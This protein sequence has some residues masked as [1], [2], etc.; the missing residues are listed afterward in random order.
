[1][2]MYNDTTK[3]GNVIK[4]VF[5]LT[6]FSHEI[7]TL[8]S[9]DKSQL[10]TIIKAQQVTN[11]K[12]SYKISTLSILLAIS[13]VA[14]I[15]L[16]FIFK[17]N[18]KASNQEIMEQKEKEITKT[19][20]TNDTTGNE[21]VD[22]SNN[23]TFQSD[24]VI[25]SASSNT[26][27]DGERKTSNRIR[28]FTELKTA[29]MHIYGMSIQGKGHIND[30][31]PCQDC[32][33]VEI[34]DTEKNIGIAVVSDGAGS[35]L[36]SAEGSKIVCE[37]SIKYLKMA[38]NKFQWLESKNLPNEMVWDKVIR[39]VIRLVQFDLNEK[40]KLMEC[41][42]RSLAATFILLYFTPEKTYFAHVG[43]GRAGVKTDEG[44]K[45]ILTPHKGEEANQTVFVSNE[46]LNPSDLKIS[47]A[48]VPE[49]I[50]IDKP[51]CAFILMSDGCEDGLWMKNKKENLP[52]GDF[53]YTA[54]NQPFVPAIEKLIQV[55]NDKQYETK[56]E[57]VLFQFM[58]RY[59]DNLKFEIDDKTLCIGVLSH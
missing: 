44:W 41:E 39:E 15:F 49:T 53:K 52:D 46:I 5:P 30:N 13:I 59:N 56:K 17:K 42:L 8:T 25:S 36:N 16:F 11:S 4:E 40:A 57:Q 21:K 45:A 1:M 3:V 51:I 20:E 34:L 14:N 7:D 19:A 9:K 10:I 18:K 33:Q 28:L 29:N 55:I 47:G 22:K 37:S 31:I 43:D 50:M 48:F 27:I 6:A 38:I 23:I 2:E 12:L 26:P 35:A 54:L 58:D 24:Q 32:H